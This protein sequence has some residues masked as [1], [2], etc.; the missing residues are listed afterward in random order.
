[1]SLRLFVAIDIPA[2]V[3][4]ELAR[5]IEQLRQIEGRAR[6]VRPEGMHVTLKFLG[7]TPAEKLPGVRT[8]LAKINS[9]NPVEIR[10]RGLGF[11]PNDRRPRVLWV[12]VEAS[13]NLAELAQ[14]VD[15]ELS[16][17]GFPAEERPF[18]PH[19]TLARLSAPS[20]W[21]ALVRATEK[22]SSQE[23]GASRESEF[24]LIESFL[25]P[26]GAE[27]KRVASFPFAKEMA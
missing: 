13:P 21:D 23:F 19:L 25:K 9:P 7:E 6:W 12:G 18:A 16:Q 24:Y 15:H 26:S 17:M 8:A 5:L 1:L 4:A 27:Y 20:R 2:T 22:L 10:F 3:R 14:K 11:F